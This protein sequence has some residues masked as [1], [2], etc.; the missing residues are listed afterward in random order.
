D[1]GPVL[2]RR[3][4]RVPAIAALETRGFALDL[5]DRADRA[6]RRGLPDLAALAPR[7]A[8]GA[9]RAHVSIAALAQLPLPP[10]SGGRAAG[11]GLGCWTRVGRRVPQPAQ[12]V[13]P[14]AR[15]PGGG[16][17]LGTVLG[18]S[19]FSS[20][21]RLAGDEGQL[22][23][24]WRTRRAGSPGMGRRARRTKRIG[25]T[26]AAATLRS[27]HDGDDVRAHA[28]VDRAAAE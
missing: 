3:D 7:A 11:Q 20:H 14:R 17:R 19:R 18:A 24:V 21:A 2:H 9:Q 6:R 28:A 15:Q 12:A 27:A 10:R 22:G 26:A 16:A 23:H 13:G 4:A 25:T 8:T 1:P 5:P